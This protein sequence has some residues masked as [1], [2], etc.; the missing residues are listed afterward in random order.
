M[1]IKLILKRL[2]DAG[3]QLAV[4]GDVLEIKAPKGV[5]TDELRALL[6]DNKAEIIDTLKLATVTSAAITP[7][8][9]RVDTDE[10]PLSPAQERL[11][12]ITRLEA[13]SAAYTVPFALRILGP[14]DIAV[15]QR[16]I[17]QV[18]QRH[19]TLRSK[20]STVGGLPVQTI[21]NNFE[22][23]L[24]VESITGSSRS[25][26]D[27]LTL[28]SVRDA[29]LLPINIY[30]DPL[31]QGR[32]LCLEEQEYVLLITMHH[33]VSDGW[34]VAI[35]FEEISKFY[36]SYLD[37]KSP[38]MSPLPIQYT[39]FAYWQRQCLAEPRR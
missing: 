34:S 6:V 27:S 15:L 8:A 5:L 2:N 14:L 24:D 33:I 9:K 21:N 10:Y 3:I 31:I 12:L 20:F 28:K 19:E 7:L 39:D 1:S 18:I 16:A 23:K 38:D 37:K 30:H 13:D 35:L 4:D 17:N 22:F 11:W 36:R 26:V 32:L 29:F 25:V